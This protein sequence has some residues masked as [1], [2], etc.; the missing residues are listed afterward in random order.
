MSKVS[1]RIKTMCFMQE[2]DLWKKSNEDWYFVFLRWLSGGSKFDQL[3]IPI[4]LRS[5]KEVLVL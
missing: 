2:T 4:K 3:S 5:L 1:V